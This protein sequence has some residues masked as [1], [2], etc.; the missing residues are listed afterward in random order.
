MPLEPPPT[1]AL[2]STADLDMEGVD[3]YQG[4]P[5]DV[6]VTHPHPSRR[7]KHTHD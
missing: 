7:A 3:D 2:D 6:R 1:A 4:G 5:N